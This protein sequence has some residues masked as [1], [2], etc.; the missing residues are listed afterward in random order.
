M[1]VLSWME[2]APHVD[3]HLRQERVVV[4]VTLDCW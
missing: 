3:A 1:D 2:R 4:D